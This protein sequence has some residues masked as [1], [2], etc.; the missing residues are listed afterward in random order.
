MK[1]KAF[2][3]RHY[4]K[5]KQLKQ[6]NRR[7]GDY[8][9]FDFSLPD[10]PLERA[11]SPDWDLLLID[12][13]PVFFRHEGAFYLTLKG[14]DRYPVECKFVT[15]DMGA[16]P[17][18]ANGADIMAPGIIDADPSIEKGDVVWVRDERNLKALSAG[19]SRCSGTKMVELSKGKVID[20]LHYV[21]DELWN[22]GF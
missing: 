17:Y 18:L 22:L 10:S 6:E 1:S 4:L 11:S 2:S 3:T 12:K 21:G 5:R 7:L 9:G 14:L 13:V 16:V 8:Y 15:V 20:T 19:V